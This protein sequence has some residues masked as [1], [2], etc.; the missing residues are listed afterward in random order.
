MTTRAK[1]TTRTERTRGVRKAPLPSPRDPAII[2]D[3]L[4]IVERNRVQAEKRA[5]E[6]REELSTTGN[7][8][9]I[10]GVS[11][12]GPMLVEPRGDSSYFRPTIPAGTSI[13]EATDD[14]WAA[15]V[16]WDG[17]DYDQAM[18]RNGMVFAKR[19]DAAAAAR[20][21]ASLLKPAA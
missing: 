6:L 14:L 2:R 11:L 20:A 15:E 3:E 19:A 7:P 13:E 12:V 16:N 5:K 8:I 18:L 17:G 10:N 1:K 21:M 9:E 4:S